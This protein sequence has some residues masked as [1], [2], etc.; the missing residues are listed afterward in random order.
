MRAHELAWRRLTLQGMTTGP[1]IARLPPASS[2]RATLVAAQARA[3]PWPALHTLGTWRWLQRPQ[4]ELD[5]IERLLK[6][7]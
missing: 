2:C 5:Y 7:Y 6:D 4:I 1:P 3:P